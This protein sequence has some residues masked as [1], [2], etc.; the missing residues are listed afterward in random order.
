ML[1]KIFLAGFLEK[2]AFTFKFI[3]CP[4]QGMGVNA[5]FNVFPYIKENFKE[6]QSSKRAFFV[7]ILHFIEKKKV[8][9]VVFIPLPCMYTRIETQL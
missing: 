4:G 1:T 7:G 2:F 3:L 6:N 8:D 9:K 5:I